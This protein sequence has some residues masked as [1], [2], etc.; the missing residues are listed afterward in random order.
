VTTTGHSFAKNSEGW[1][2]LDLAAYYRLD[3]RKASR[4]YFRQFYP[5]KSGIPLDE[6]VSRRGRIYPDVGRL[7]PDV[8]TSHVKVAIE[9]EVDGRPTMAMLRSTAF[10]PPALPASEVWWETTA[11]ISIRSM[12]GEFY[13]PYDLVWFVGLRGGPIVRRDGS[14]VLQVNPRSPGVANASDAAELIYWNLYVCPCLAALYAENVRL[15][16]ASIRC[17]ARN[18]VRSI[19]H[20]TGSRMRHRVDSLIQGLLG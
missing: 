19:V 15:E 8:R 13:D 20:E 10:H 11:Y 6:V 9:L 5:T 16:K 12:E 1:K 18:G 14:P 7:Y 3:G 4:E 2:G 17:G